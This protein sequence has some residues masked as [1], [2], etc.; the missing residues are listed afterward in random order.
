MGKD[1]AETK[2]VQDLSKALK[3]AP[4]ENTRKEDRIFI[5]FSPAV[6]IGI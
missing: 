3:Q 5:L 1:L 4:R 2:I 6:L